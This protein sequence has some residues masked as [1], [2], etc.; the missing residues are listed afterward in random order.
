LGSC[1]PP[2]INLFSYLYSPTI[3]IEEWWPVANGILKVMSFSILRH[4]GSAI[5]SQFKVLFLSVKFESNK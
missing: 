3:I 1:S 2:I 4:F 5:L